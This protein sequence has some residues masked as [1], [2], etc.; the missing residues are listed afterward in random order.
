MILY[1]TKN[2]NSRGFTFIEI[3]VTLLV[4]AILALILFTF[5]GTGVTR[6]STP[7]I[8]TKNQYE[9]S[10][11]MDKITADYRNAVGSTAFNLSSF[12]TQIEGT[13][14]S[15]IT[16]AYTD[17]TWNGSDYEE[18]GSDTNILK[19]TVGKGNQAIMALF[20]M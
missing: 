12:K 7:V 19:V 10:E 11:V 6:S 3:I 20:T 18:S 13:Y 16:T 2:R 8:W 14:S 9:L 15:Y 5:M 17:F 1:Y 4:A